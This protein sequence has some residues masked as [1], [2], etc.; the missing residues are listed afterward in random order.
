MRTL[1][2][3]IPTTLLVA[4][5]LLVGIMVSALEKSGFVAQQQA[6]RSYTL[7][8]GDAIGLPHPEQTALH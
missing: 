1:T 2:L 5:V 6:D 8:S 3:L 7:I 4:A